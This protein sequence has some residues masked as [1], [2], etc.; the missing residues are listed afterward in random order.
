LK[1]FTVQR[2]GRLK[3][4]HG[5]TVGKVHGWD[6]EVQ[7]LT[8][9]RLEKVTVRRWNENREVRRYRSVATGP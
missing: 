3:E 1:R 7:G 5:S 4:V 8:G 9:Y 2:L 6:S